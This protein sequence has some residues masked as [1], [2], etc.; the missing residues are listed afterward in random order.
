M[1]TCVH[2]LVTTRR[3]RPLPSMTNTLLIT[4]WLFVN[5]KLVIALD[6]H[7]RQA[8]KAA[9]VDLGSI[10]PCRLLSDRF[11]E[12]AAELCNTCLIFRSPNQDLF[13]TLNGYCAFVAAFTPS[14]LVMKKHRSYRFHELGLSGNRIETNLASHV[15]GHG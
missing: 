12:N 6:G 5:R 2:C 15:I 14:L 4:S 8:V 11:V 7:K 13:V 9:Y 3:K 1:K 10:S